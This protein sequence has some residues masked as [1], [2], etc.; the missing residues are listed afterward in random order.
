MNLVFIG[1]VLIECWQATVLNIVVGVTRPG[2]FTTVASKPIIKI[3]DN[4]KLSTLMY[5]YNIAMLLCR[6]LTDARNQQD[7][8]QIAV[9]NY[10]CV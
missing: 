4:L 10:W 5:A 3:M 2:S 8:S 9:L 1:R 7:I 6:L